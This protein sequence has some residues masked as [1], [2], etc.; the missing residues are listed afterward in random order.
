LLYFAGDIFD[1]SF[2]LVLVH[3]HLRIV[4]VTPQS[5]I[6]TACNPGGI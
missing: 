6:S 1:A 2:D 5:Q 4:R 3:S